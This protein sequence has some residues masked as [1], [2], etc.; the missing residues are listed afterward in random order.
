MP[1]C[2]LNTFLFGEGLVGEITVT[3]RVLWVEPTGLTGN[4][5]FSLSPGNDY[6]IQYNISIHSKQKV[7]LNTAGVLPDDPGV[8]IV[9]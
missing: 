1:L 8:L 4:I 2:F 5:R 3:C 6:R 9:V 7:T